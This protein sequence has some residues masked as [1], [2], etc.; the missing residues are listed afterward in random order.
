[1][2]ARSS[3][4]A[5]RLTL[6]RTRRETS[7]PR[8]Y[9]LNT[10]RSNDRQDRRSCRR[11]QSDVLDVD[12][13]GR[14][15]SLP[16]GVLEIGQRTGIL[17]VFG[18]FPMTSIGT[19]V[20]ARSGSVLSMTEKRRGCRTLAY[21]EDTARQLSCDHIE[22]HRGHD[23]RD[24]GNFADLDDRSRSSWC[25]NCIPGNGCFTTRSAQVQPMRRALDRAAMESLLSTRAFFPCCGRCF[26]IIQ[27]AAGF[28]R[29]DP[30]AAELGAP[31]CASRSI[32]AKGPMS[33]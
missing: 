27:S 19:N 6:R 1:M 14:K 31:L 29:D 32:P 5:H 20:Q 9:S 28:F 23:C 21:L 30:N 18:R 7:I 33:R 15:T 3:A 10:A 26:R 2:A 17:G 24:D 25:S 8:E 13:C 22:R 12:Q 16:R 4:S 11:R